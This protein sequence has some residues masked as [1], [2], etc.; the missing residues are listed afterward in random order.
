MTPLTYERE[1]SP[2]HVA[3]PIC[4]TA[5]N[6]TTTIA[7]TTGHRVRRRGGGAGGARSGRIGNGIGGR[8]GGG[9]GGRRGGCGDGLGRVGGLGLGRALEHDDH[10]PPRLVIGEGG[11]DLGGP[12]PDHLLVQLR[13]PSRDRGAAGAALD[14]HPGPGGG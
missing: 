2:N 5:I 9:G 3:T 8:R 12:T 13:E 11:E 6:A 10:L 14:W 1:S 4:P 7:T